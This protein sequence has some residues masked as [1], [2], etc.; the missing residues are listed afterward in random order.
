MLS[1][2]VGYGVCF[3]CITFYI[4]SLIFFFCQLTGMNTHFD[5]GASTGC[6][7]TDVVVELA[8]ILVQLCVGVHMSVWESK[9]SQSLEP[10]LPRHIFSGFSQR[11]F[12]G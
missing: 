1:S 3:C 4:R 12:D 7:D 2:R 6:L 10:G 5:R 11:S 9:P 8:A